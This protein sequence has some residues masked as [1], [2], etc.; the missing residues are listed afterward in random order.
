MGFQAEKGKYAM[1]SINR[2]NERTFE[3]S[4]PEIKEVLERANE[5]GTLELIRDVAAVRGRIDGELYARLNAH[6]LIESLGP[7]D[8]SVIETSMIKDPAGALRV[9]LVRGLNVLYRRSG[10]SRKRLSLSSDWQ[11]VGLIATSLIEE[12]TAMSS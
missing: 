12:I 2:G 3:I 4:Q 6:P 9:L 1:G 10:R 5:I 7:K 11:E 8:R